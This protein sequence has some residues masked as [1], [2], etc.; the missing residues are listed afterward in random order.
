MKVILTENV[1]D[2]GKKMQIV[3]VKQGFANN[4]LFKKNLALP[5]TKENIKKLE[6]ELA[7]I[8]ANEAELKALA[9]K[10]KELLDGY[11]MTM[12]V[13]SGPEGRLYGAVTTQEIADMLYA[14]KNINIDKRK[15][16]CDTIK[17]LGTYD[18][19]IKLH[20]QVEA[21]IKLEVERE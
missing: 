19:R 3:D 6:K 2:L 16:I 13:K 4:F 14:Q 11:T 12:K 15:I 10:N 7:E 18:I 17:D 8:A 21:M 5:A 1:E 9:E 20:Q